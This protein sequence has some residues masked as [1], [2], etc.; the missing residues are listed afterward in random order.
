MLQDVRSWIKIVLRDEGSRRDK[1]LGIKISRSRSKCLIRLSK[2]TY[3]DKILKHF[4]TKGSK[5]GN[6]PIEHS[7]YLSRTQSPS[8]K[9]D[10]K[11]IKGVP[12][13][14]NQLECH[15]FVPHPGTNGGY[16]DSRNSVWR[17]Q[18]SLAVSRA[19]GDKHLTKWVIVE[20]ETRIL[21]IRPDCEFLILASDGIWDMVS[22]QEAIDI[23]LPFC[24]VT[25]KPDLFSACKKLIGLSTTRG[26]YD[27]MSVM[28]REE[29]RQLD[30]ELRQLSKENKSVRGQD[31]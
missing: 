15:W 30:K 14:F 31:F 27:N 16:V 2:S 5:K 18:G 3:I 25:E 13:V 10:M 28:L 7:V 21:N 9:E 1:V 23:V 11:R 19:I 6:L 29:G 20:P 22:N 26:S 17:I 8:T 24:I 12:C 4:K